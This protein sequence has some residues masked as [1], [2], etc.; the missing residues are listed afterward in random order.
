MVCVSLC[1]WWTVVG[2]PC[3]TPPL[4]PGCCLPPTSLPSQS[5]AAGRCS[6]LQPAPIGC[7]LADW[8]LGQQPKSA[9]NRRLQLE[10]VWQVA[11]CEE[12]HFVGVDTGAAWLMCGNWQTIPCSGTLTQ[13][14]EKQSTASPSQPLTQQPTQIQQPLEHP[15]NSFTGWYRQIKPWL[16]LMPPY[17]K[18]A[19]HY[20]SQGL[21]RLSWHCR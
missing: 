3:L 18:L 12:L 9:L 14:S 16:S 17:Q 6:G 10:C 11:S 2:Q 1:V 19:L 13:Q 20:T 7:C 5:T 4:S 15:S 8:Q 21:L